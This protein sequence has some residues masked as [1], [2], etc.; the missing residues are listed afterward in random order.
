MSDE[1]LNWRLGSQIEF[2][3]VK[4]FGAPP[5]PELACRRSPTD[6]PWGRAQDFNMGRSL[7]DAGLAEQQRFRRMSNT[8]KQAVA[9]RGAVNSLPSQF[10]DKAQELLA[11]ANLAIMA[12]ALA[13]WVGAHATPVGWVMDIGM[14]S[15]PKELGASTQAGTIRNVNAVGGT[16]N[17]VNC[18]VA[19]DATLAGQAASALPGGPY[20]ISILEKHY[21]TSFGAP[22]SI[23]S[24]TDAM[25]AAGPGARGIVFGSRGSEVGHVFN[26]ANQNGVVQF[27][28]G[29]TGHAATLDGFNHFQLLRTN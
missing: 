27:L 21:G 5:G 10:R 13:I 16:M 24:I 15:P 2:D 11:P 20:R 19:T 23:S 7:V 29:Q 4:A 28:D 26:V 12:G 22:G 6:S 17:C 9:L 18:V 25:S 1:L 8:D 14:V 3:A